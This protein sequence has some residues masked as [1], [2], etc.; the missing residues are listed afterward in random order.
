MKLLDLPALLKNNAYPGRGIV[1]GMSPDGQQALFAYFIMGRSDNSRNRVF[2]QEG[3]ELTIRL[4]DEA[5]LRD[6]SLILYRPTAT[7]GHSLIVTNGDQTDT[8]V[9][10]LK[11]GGSFESAL[12]TRA[13]EPDAPNFTPRISGMMSFEGGSVC[14]QMGLLRASDAQGSACDRHYYTYPALAGTGRFIHTYLQDGNPLPSF[15]GEPR[16]IAIPND[17]EAFAH[18]V[19]DSLH[20]D[21]KVALCVRTYDIAAHTSRFLLFN[22]H[23]V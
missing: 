3:D 9:S 7:V 5:K 8:I 13:F 22:R 1:M 10:S 17:A 2:V 15:C 20:K 6:A 4:H 11:E 16:P 21:N 23:A 14:I 18:A 12:N 19:W